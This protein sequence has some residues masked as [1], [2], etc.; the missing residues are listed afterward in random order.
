MT[1]VVIQNQQRDVGSTLVW[2]I[3]AGLVA[4]GVYFLIDTNFINYNEPLEI[5]ATSSKYQWQSGKFSKRFGN[6]LLVGWELVDKEVKLFMILTD[7][8]KLHFQI[9]Y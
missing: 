8:K 6:F 5:K 4:L 3:L 2:V 1:S 9:N 7:L